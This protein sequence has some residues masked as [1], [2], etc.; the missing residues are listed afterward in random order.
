MSQSVLL[1]TPIQLFNEKKKNTTHL[2]ESYEEE[3]TIAVT[4]KLFEQKG[5]YE[6]E[7]GI[8]GR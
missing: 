2:H 4:T 1:I 6:G 7:T 3:E 8:L 5:R